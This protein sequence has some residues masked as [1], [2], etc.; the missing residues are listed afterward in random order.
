MPLD[1]FVVVHD[2]GSDSGVR[3]QPTNLCVDELL[4][5]PIWLDLL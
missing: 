2:D 3:R 4:Q 1:F 5:V